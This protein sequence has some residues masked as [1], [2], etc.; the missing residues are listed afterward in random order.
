MGWKQFQMIRRMRLD[1]EQVV[2]GMTVQLG[3]S[4]SRQGGAGGTLSIVGRSGEEYKVGSDE[5]SLGLAG[6]ELMAVLEWEVP[7]LSTVW[8]H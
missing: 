8:G 1:W 3:S 5:F 4:L 7:G 2:G 6:L